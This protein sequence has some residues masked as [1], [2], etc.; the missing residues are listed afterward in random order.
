MDLSDFSPFSFAR[1]G[2]QA[3]QDLSQGL[4][5]LVAGRLWA[6]I[7]LALALGILVGFIMSPSLGWISVDWSKVIVAWLAFPG[8]IFLSLIQ[9]VII[10][11]VFASVVLGIVSSDSLQ[12]LRTLGLKI[13]VYYVFTTVVSVGLGF[14]VAYAIRPGRFINPESLEV[15]AGESIVA[16]TA[17]EGQNLTNIVSGLIP[18][19]PF[20]VLV[21]GEML[22]VVLLAMFTGVALMS[23]KDEDAKPLVG[24]LNSFQKISMIVIGWAMRLAPL[25]V[26]G[27]TAGLFVQVGVDALLGV[28]VYLFTVIM[29]L[30]LVLVFYLILVKFM[31]KESPFEFLRKIR[32]VQLLAF[33]TSSSAS[34]MPL[35]IETAENKLSVKPSISQFVIPLGTTVNMDGTALYQGV[36][37]IFL[38]QVFSVDLSAGQLL[39]V[40]LTATLSSIGAPGAPGVGMG[41]LSVILGNVGIPP[42]GIILILG[43]DRI[44]DMCRTVINVTGDL[45]AALVMDRWK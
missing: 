33:S 38:A 39:L 42:G 41:I 13:G 5:R 29:G 24:L 11:L 30:F 15:A 22:Q 14:L 45:T 3:V 19:N 43:V 7:I 6:K 17:V 34:V 25:A 23:L 26:F 35:T 2:R 28:G 40:V 32:D 1:K 20:S 27:L 12:Q 9:L 21:S 16:P 8:Q 10:P 37:T 18:N 31:A 4:D 44:L 36:A